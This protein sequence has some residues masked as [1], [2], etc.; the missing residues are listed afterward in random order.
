VKPSE[1]RRVGDVAYAAHTI[2]ARNGLT[3][4]KLTRDWSAARSTPNGDGERVKTSTL[5]DPTSAAALNRDSTARYHERYVRLL[6]ETWE[7]VAEYAALVNAYN[8][9]PQPNRSELDRVKLVMLRGTTPPPSL[10]VNATSAVLKAVSVLLD[11]KES[12]V[13]LNAANTD[14]ERSRDFEKV[15]MRV[16]DKAADLRNLVAE[17]IQNTDEDGNPTQKKLRR[18][19]TIALCAEDA[20]REPVPTPRRGRCPACYVWARRWS[21]KHDGQPAP[22]VP[23][24]VI[25][26]RHEKREQKRVA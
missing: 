1:L 2:V 5:S 7:S 11:R 10:L 18:E 12:L 15:T 8:R 19:R 13:A 17:V 20:C 24:E 23:R 26:A 4:W 3:C 6:V 9:L 16:F 14:R 21:S 25:E 22:P